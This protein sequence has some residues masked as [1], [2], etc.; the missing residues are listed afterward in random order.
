M[1]SGMAKPVRTIGDPDNRLPEKR[2][3]AVF[4]TAV[5]GMWGTPVCRLE[6][7]WLL[8]SCCCMHTVNISA[9]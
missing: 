5:F 6:Y 1:F 3:S 9:A 7:C 2:S 4:D 8:S